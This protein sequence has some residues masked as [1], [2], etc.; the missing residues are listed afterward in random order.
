MSALIDL[1]GKTFGRLKVVCREENDNSGGARWLC[2]C[3]CGKES[4]VFGSSLRK[5]A[6]RSCGCYSAEQSAKRCKAQAKH[7]ME[8]TPTYRSWAAMKDRCLNKSSKDFPAYGGRG[9]TVCSK[10]SGSFETFLDDMG[11][12]PEGM[13]I[14]R[15]DNAKGY[16]HKN[17]KWATRAEQARNRR[18]TK[19]T[20]ADIT[21]IRK[22]G[23][24]LKEIA[25]EYG[26]GITQIGKI[27]RGEQ[28]T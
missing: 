26:V 21:E 18:S 1:A 8:G 14:E 6:T 22:D 11:S 3:L 9:V 10:W 12:R 28:W 20:Y 2:I 5:G 27:K 24:K 17:C 25:T 23:R 19:L 7:G 4:I 13:T 15:V 16:F